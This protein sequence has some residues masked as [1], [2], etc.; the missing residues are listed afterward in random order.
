[1][2]YDLNMK[3]LLHT[4]SHRK[5]T[6]G[7]TFVEVIIAVFLF[8]VIVA[9]TSGF[10]VYYFSNYSFTFEQQ[11]QVGQAQSA[12]TQ[13]IREIRKARP[14]DDGSWPLVQT[15]DAVFIF[16][17]DVNGDNR[18]DRVRYFLSGNELRRGII[19]P[20]AV[21]VT[22]PVANEVITTLMTSVEATSSPIFRYYNG[23]WPADT[24][25]NPLSPANRILNTRFVKIDVRL[26]QTTNFAAEPFELSSGV[27]IRSMKNNL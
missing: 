11:Q 10:V 5:S 8:T 21:P 12:L 16:Y 7:F 4:N 27:S 9:L 2:Q 26:N 6:H 17:A 3:Y 1:M 19:Q 22:Y 20:T 24:T 25:N 23:D 15:D 13:M 14:G 18:S